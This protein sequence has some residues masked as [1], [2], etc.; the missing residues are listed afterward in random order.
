MYAGMIFRREPIFKGNDNHD[1]LVKIARILGTESLFDYLDKYNLTLHEV[2][3]NL[4]S[5]EKYQRQP[6][7]RFINDTN[8]HLVS[9]DALDFLD[10]L[11][12]YDH[13]ERLPPVE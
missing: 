8:S 4:L 13:Q 9:K 10:K 1:Q 11:L 7:T 12:R 3:D 6:W 2:F 5:R